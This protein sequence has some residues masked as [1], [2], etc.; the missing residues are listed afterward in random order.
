M[1][2]ADSARTATAR[3]LARRECS[4]L[5]VRLWEKRTHLPVGAPLSPF[6]DFLEHFV[7]EKPSQFYPI[8][9]TTEPKTWVQALP[10]L[11]GLLEQELSLWRDAALAS[12]PHAAARRAIENLE[13]ELDPDEARILRSISDGSNRMG[14]LV[15]AVFGCPL[16]AT[17]V[18][19]TNK[20]RIRVIRKATSELALQRMKLLDSLF[21][22][23]IK[24]KKRSKRRKGVTRK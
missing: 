4:N 21:K 11:R 15:N 22:P 13:Q 19:N 16:T 7:K 5:V 24:V 23:S 1:Q 9:V 18:P 20:E 6:A 12:Q 3:E 2:L 10:T 8:E 17:P 14:L